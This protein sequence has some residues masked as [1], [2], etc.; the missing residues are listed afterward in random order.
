LPE[1]LVKTAIERLLEIGLLESG[2]NKS[3]KKSELTSHPGAGI[4]QDPAG[5]PQESAVEGKGTEHHHQEGKRKERKRTHTEPNGTESSGTERAREAPTTEHSAASGAAVASSKNGDDADENPRVRYASP[6]D[7]LKAIYLT[8][9]GESITV[10][11]LAA[12]RENLELSGVT[13]GDFVADVGKHVQNEW[14]NPA[15]FLRDRSKPFH[16][17]TRPAARPVTAAIAAAE[18]YRCPHCHSTIPGEGAVPGEGGTF[19]PCSCASPDYVARQ[20]ARG[21][22]PPEEDQ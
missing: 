20:R 21:V 12:I 17:K 10:A 11:L 19:V 2:G 16:A 14:R 7:E 5:Q 15:G 1:H 22:F 18:A 13:M 9:A 3:R 8:K 6:D 4:S